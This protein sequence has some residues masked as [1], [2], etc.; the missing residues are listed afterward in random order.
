[1]NQQE[2]L[3]MSRLYGPLH[4]SL[5]DRFDT[6]RLADNTE[7]RIVL[8]EIPPEH[9][10]FIE[11]RDMFFL[12]TID[13]QGR[14][15]VSYKGGDPGFVRV[16]DNQ[17]VA[18]PCYDGNGMFY[19]MG[20]VLGNRHVGMLFVNFEK[21]HRLRLQGIASVDD[22]DP[23]LTVYA[24]AQ[25]IVRVRVS[26]IFRNCPRYVHHY[27]KIE[28]SKFV[29]RSTGETPIAPWK[30]VDDIQAA[31]PARDRTRVE[32]EGGVISRAEYEKYITEV[33]KR[34]T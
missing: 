1:L 22:N 26:E 21:P 24:E 15:T 5:Q 28:P 6:R 18:F 23:L 17:T 11:S 9:K 2:R 4:R 34:E 10:A 32:R 31:L 20:N 25:L 7:A 19:S 29:P 30:R 8:T 33:V 13:H 14:P 27:K 16:L 12:S 3:T